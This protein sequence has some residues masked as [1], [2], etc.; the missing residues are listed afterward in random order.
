MDLAEMA[1]RSEDL[2]LSIA[3]L[4]LPPVQLKRSRS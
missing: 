3:Y 2:K 1:G 4:E